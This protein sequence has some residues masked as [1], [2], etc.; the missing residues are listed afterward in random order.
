MAQQNLVSFQISGGEME[1]VKGAITVLK[2]VLL[3]KLKTLSPEERHD[4]PKMGDKSVAFVQKAI[5][6]CRENPELVPQFLDMEAVRPVYIP[7]LQIGEA[8]SDTMILSGSEAYT[9][10]FIFYNAMKAAAK[11]KI[12]KTNSIYN[13]LSSRFPNKPKAASADFPGTPR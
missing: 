1:A 11:S 3:P 6:Y 12:P 13:D 4:L 2:N 7:L 9:A 5:E 8:L 10:A